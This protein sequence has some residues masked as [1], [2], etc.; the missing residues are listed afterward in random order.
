MILPIDWGCY[1]ST[2]LIHLE[3]LKRPIRL[4][5]AQWLFSDLLG[6]L[7]FEVRRALTELKEKGS[8]TIDNGGWIRVREGY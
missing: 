8:I 2:I 6:M 5:T 3:A 7:D 1:K 4:P